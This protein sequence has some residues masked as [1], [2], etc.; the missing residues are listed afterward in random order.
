MFSLVKKDRVTCKVTKTCM[1]TVTEKKRI[2]GSKGEECEI[3]LFSIIIKKRERNTV[4]FK[5]ECLR[6]NIKLSKQNIV[7]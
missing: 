7:R 2:Q 1:Y 6:L 4:R 3:N 5:K